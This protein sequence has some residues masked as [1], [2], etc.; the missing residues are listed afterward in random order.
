MNSGMRDAINLSWKL[1]AVIK[2]DASPTLLDSYEIERRDH[3]VKLTKIANRLG[4][5]IMPTQKWRAA[6][7]DFLLKTLTA[8]AVTNELLRQTFFVPPKHV[9]GLFVKSGVGRTRRN[10]EMIVQPQVA[11]ACGKKDFL[12]NF[13]APGF[14]VL[15]IGQDPLSSLPAAA[16]DLCRE[17]KPQ[18]VHVARDEKPDGAVSEATCLSD[19]DEVIK[20][21]LG[22][23]P[24]FLL[25]RPDRFV[26]TG[27]D[28]ETATPA[29]NNFI[30]MMRQ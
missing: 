20:D 8:F 16:L 7:R 13:L 22:N 2:G 21:W 27:F 12:D 3:V 1:A 30:A 5:I 26:A 28:A 9:E 17:L 4:S 15:G 23:G 10:G 18:F 29:L 24:A 19:S 11:D 6:L 25:V 14:V